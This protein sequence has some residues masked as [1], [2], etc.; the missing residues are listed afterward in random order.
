MSFGKKCRRWFRQFLVGRL[1]QKT[2]TVVQKFRNL[3]YDVTTITAVIDFT[4]E[5][6]LIND[7]ITMTK[8]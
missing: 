8:Y 4:I 5:V 1:V 3:T 2:K 6:H 7:M